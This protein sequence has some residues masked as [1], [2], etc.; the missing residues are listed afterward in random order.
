METTIMG[1]MLQ[2][3]GFRGSEGMDKKMEAAIM[4]Y[5]G[6]T[7]RMSSFTPS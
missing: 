6:T 4:G 3:L 2:G 1:C 7:M 5:M